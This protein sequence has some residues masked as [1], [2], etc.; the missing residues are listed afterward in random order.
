MWPNILVWV[1]VA[2]VGLICLRWVYQRLAGKQGSGCGCGSA[3]CPLR[4]GR[5]ACSPSSPEIQN[6]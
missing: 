3:T 5:N 4:D 2:A 1:I 6:D